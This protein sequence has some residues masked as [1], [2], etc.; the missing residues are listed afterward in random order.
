MGEEKKTFLKEYPYLFLFT[1]Q[2][3]SASVAY[4]FHIQ[5][6]SH[7]I[8]RIFQQPHWFVAWQTWSIAQAEALAIASLAG[9]PNEFPPIAAQDQEFH[10]TLLYHEAKVS[11]MLP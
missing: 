8:S 6:I 10:R 1:V 5:Y 9:V 4:T 3:F 2:N 7:I 11:C